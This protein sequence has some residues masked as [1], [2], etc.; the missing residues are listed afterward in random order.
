MCLLTGYVFAVYVPSS[1]W[2]QND[3]ENENDDLSS[4][5]RPFIW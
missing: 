1:V 4:K 2:W 5:R 3:D